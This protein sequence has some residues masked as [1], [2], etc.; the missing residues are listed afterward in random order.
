[1]QLYIHVP[2]CRK[3]CAYC[4]FYS[5]PLPS[6]RAGADMARRYLT[7]LLGELRLW[8]DRI[9]NRPVETI[10]FGGGTPSMLPAR[11]VAG[12][13]EAAAKHFAVD[14]AAEITAEANPDSALAD[15][16][17]FEARQAGVN[18]LSLGVQSFDDR[19]L[20]LLGRAHD[21]RTA[22]AAVHTARSAGFTNLSLDLMW[23]LPGEPGRP[24]AQM[25]WLAELERALELRPEHV[26]AYGFTLEDDTPMARECGEG[27]Y[28]LPDEKAAASMYLAGAEYLQSRG[29]MQY[30]ISNYARMGFE[31]RHNL[32]YWQGADYLGIGPGATS[33]LEGRRWTNPCD[34]DAWAEKV[35]AASIGD[36]AEQLDDAALRKE[37]VMLALRTVKGLSLAEWKQRHG[38][39]FLKDHA[40]LVALLQKEGLAATRQGRFRLTRTGMLVSD[41]ILAHFFER[42]G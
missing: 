17:L 14:P 41:S 13:L 30:E 9:G 36:D 8:A 37:R 19:R 23:G 25:Q 16:W 40:P 31:C 18:R 2:F 38:G 26:S 33:T 12:I 24:Q 11:A 21:A 28:S 27:R 15:G 3:K 34:L 1:M 42:L 20:A 29:Y 32:G 35:R 4:A 22:E 10:F 7:G 39:D 6:D 5:V